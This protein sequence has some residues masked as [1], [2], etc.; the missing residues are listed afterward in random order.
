MSLEPRLQGVWDWRAAGNFIGGGTGTGLILAAAA[1]AL[2]GAPWQRPLLVG[3]A[4]VAAGLALVWA[5]IGRPLRA[6]NVWFNPHTSWMT[7]ESL[8]AGPLLGAALAGAWLGWPLLLALAAVLAAAFLYCQARLV[9]AARGIPAW[10]ADA[11]VGL[12]VATGL[13]EGTG[14]ALALAAL[15]PLPGRGARLLLALALLVLLAARAWAWRRY[16]AGLAAPRAARA[17]LE[18]LDA[19]LLLAGTVAPVALV[20][21]GLVWPVTARGMEAAAGLAALGAGWALK[22]VL[23]TRAGHEQGFA[24]PHSPARGAGSP[25]PGVRPGWDEGR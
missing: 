4:A 8:L 12:L 10:R 1:A 7:R 5:E 15:P 24:I 21:A 13:A 9:H 16:L 22:R 17:V 18:R 14:L 2:A 11:V 3:A 19:P 23:I 25:G 20:L 6:I